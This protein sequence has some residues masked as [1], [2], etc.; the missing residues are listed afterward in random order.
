MSACGTLFL[1]IGGRPGSL[2][3]NQTP[4]FGDNPRLAGDGYI[5]LAGVLLVVGLAATAL[6]GRLRLPGLVVLLAVC[7]LAGSQGIGGIS[8]SDYQ[9]AQVAGKATGLI[10]GQP[11]ARPPSNRIRDRAMI[12]ATCAAW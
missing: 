10:S 8:F 4:R 5:L 6:A 2:N 11:A 7:M 12:P 3:L 1:L 9:A